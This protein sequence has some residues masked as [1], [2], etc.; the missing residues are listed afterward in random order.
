[1]STDLKITHLG[2]KSS[3]ASLEKY[4]FEFSKLRNWHYMWSFYYYHKKNYGIIIALKKS[5]SRLL[6][7]FIKFI[8]YFLTFDKKNKILYFCRFSGL[9][10]SI[11]NKKSSFRIKI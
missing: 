5:T 7:Y 1:M 9:I 3:L 8:F 11:C 4:K 10:N 6:R 2:F